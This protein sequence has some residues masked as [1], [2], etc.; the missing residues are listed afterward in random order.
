[1]RE[2]CSWFLHFTCED[3]L[4]HR[5]SRTLHKSQPWTSELMSIFVHLPIPSFAG[6]GSPADKCGTEKEKLSLFIIPSLLQ[7]IRYK[8][9]S[10]CFSAC[11]FKIIFLGGQGSKYNLANWVIHCI[12]RGGSM[13]HKNYWN[14]SAVNPLLVHVALRSNG[15]QEW[16]FESELWHIIKPHTL[17]GPEKC[18][19]QFLYTGDLYSG[20]RSCERN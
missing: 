4:S 2:V 15:K 9:F 3:E 6:P 7:K 5:T 14:I 19:E 12:C 8:H 1:M 17:S 13:A 18:F 10:M 16:C 11:L 20:V